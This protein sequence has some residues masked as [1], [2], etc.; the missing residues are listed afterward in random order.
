[1]DALILFS[2]RVLSQMLLMVIARPIPRRITTFIRKTDAQCVCLVLDANFS[3]YVSPG[4][5][6]F[7]PNIEHE[8]PTGL[9]TYPA[10]VSFLEVFLPVILRSFLDKTCTYTYL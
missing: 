3:R 1:M 9:D 4:H 2:A 7:L 8:K 10:I 5:G 6:Y